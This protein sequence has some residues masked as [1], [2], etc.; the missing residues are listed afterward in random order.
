MID[1]LKIVPSEQL[2]I[3]ARI[4]A[5]V[6]ERVTTILADHF[7]E[8]WARIEHQ[9][10]AVTGVGSKHFKHGTPVIGIK[11]EVAIPRQNALERSGK[12]KT[13]H[14]CNDPLLVR[15]ALPAQRNER[16]RAIDTCYPHSMSHKIARDGHIFATSKV[17]DTCTLVQQCDEAVMP[18]L[19]FQPLLL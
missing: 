16:W 14:V 19:S 7:A 13:A 6:I 18:F 17:E 9:D 1:N 2:V 3:F 12:P 15:E 11:L 8:G 4:E 10:R 5:R